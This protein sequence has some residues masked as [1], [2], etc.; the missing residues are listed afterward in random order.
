MDARQ[1][2]KTKEKDENAFIPYDRVI[3]LLT[4]FGEM[5]EFGFKGSECDL[6]IIRCPEC[7]STDVIGGGVDLFRCMD[8]KC[9]F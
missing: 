5:Q 1:F 3:E 7:N 8:C 4:E 9:K 6:D 2:L